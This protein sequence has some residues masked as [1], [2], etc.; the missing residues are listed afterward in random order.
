MYKYFY[1]DISP[2]HNKWMVRL[3]HDNVLFPRGTMGSYNVLCAR[4]INLPYYDYLRLCRDQYNA[5]L[6][7]KNSGYVV[8]YYDIK[9]DCDKMVKELNRRMEY[10]MRNRKSNQ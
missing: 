2:I 9:E 6:V 7:G 1:S 5:T 3:H 10:I 8:P 4:V